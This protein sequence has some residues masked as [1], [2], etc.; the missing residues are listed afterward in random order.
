[1]VGHDYDAV[2]ARDR[3]K[4]YKKLGSFLRS[5]FQTYNNA[6]LSV[7]AG[8]DATATFRPVM[9][10][11]LDSGLVKKNTTTIQTSVLHDIDPLTFGRFDYVNKFLSG[12]TVPSDCVDR[13]NYNTTYYGLVL[14]N[15]FS[16]LDG[17]GTL[18][19]TPLSMA[20]I[21]VFQNLATRY[22]LTNACI[23]IP[24]PT[25]NGGTLKVLRICK[26]STDCYVPS[27]TM[28]ESL[29]TRIV[30]GTT[31]SVAEVPA[32]TCY[33]DQFKAVSIVRSVY[34]YNL[35]PTMSNTSFVVSDSASYIDDVN[36]LISEIIRM[37]TDHDPKSP[38]FKGGWPVTLTT[39]NVNFIT[40][41]FHSSLTRLIRPAAMIYP[42]YFV[43]NSRPIFN[44]V[45]AVL[46]MLE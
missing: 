19:L 10:L 38:I 1:M 37:Y 39:D 27:D 33:T 40:A 43:D 21:K 14:T 15:A 28:T 41:G 24:I 42:Y 17:D 13:A 18:C 11:L 32:D 31:T 8:A 25:T 23:D 3:I 30:I 36:T 7:L 45:K 22:A 5:L 34:N 20:L 29:L 26:T 44:P 9:A 16:Y 2:V 12:T 4:S 6:V 35:V 46:G